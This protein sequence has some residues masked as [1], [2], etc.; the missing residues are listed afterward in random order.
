LEVKVQYFASTREIV[1]LREE[2]LHLDQG[3]K[4]S[5]LLKILAVR[6]SKLRDY[7]FDPKTGIPRPYLQFMIDD[8]QIANLNGYDTILPEKCTFAIIP[9]VGG[10]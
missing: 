1:N 8:N 9:P 3:T 4:V 5:D 7:I 2:I 10:G 6:H